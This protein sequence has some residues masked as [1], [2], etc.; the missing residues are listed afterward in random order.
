MRFLSRSILGFIVL[1]WGTAHLRAESGGEKVTRFTVALY[2]A[3]TPA[4]DADAALSALLEGRFAALAQPGAGLKVTS[5]W[6][7]IEKV[8]L[9]GPEA[10]QYTTKDVAADKVSPLRQC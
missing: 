8:P 1:G 7:N 9:P 3:P 6:A 4:T 5:E 10:L 2:F